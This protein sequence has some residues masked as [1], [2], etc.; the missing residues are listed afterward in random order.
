MAEEAAKLGKKYADQGMVNTGAPAA[1]A[2][3]S[4]PVANLAASIGLTQ[5][6][7]ADSAANDGAGSPWGAMQYGDPGKLN[8]PKDASAMPSFAGSEGY[9]KLLQAMATNRERSATPRMPE[10]GMDPYAASRENTQAGTLADVGHD[11]W[12][13]QQQ[14]LKYQQNM[15]LQQYLS[16]LENYQREE[17]RRNAFIDQGGRTAYGGGQAILSYFTKGGFSGKKPDK[18]NSTGAPAAA[19]PSR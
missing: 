4:D 3:G 17:E 14:M 6:G 11:S 16:D 18:T 13:G 5:K 15:A 12:I 7:M 8:L 2:L 10:S 9:D 19:G 1:L